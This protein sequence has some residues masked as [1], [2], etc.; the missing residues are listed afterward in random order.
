MIARCVF[1]MI[2]PPSTLCLF[3]IAALDV[4]SMPRMK[5]SIGKDACID[6]TS[7]VESL[8]SDSVVPSCADSGSNN[9]EFDELIF[10]GMMRRSI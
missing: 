1:V 4:M 8:L 2:F 9:V 5:T 3:F 10:A 7:D 6:N